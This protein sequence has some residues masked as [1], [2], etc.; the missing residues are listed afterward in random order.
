MGPLLMTY[1]LMSHVT[2]YRSLS[3]FCSMVI[4][5]PFLAY[6]RSY[7]LL[8]LTMQPWIHCNLCMSIT[9]ISLVVTSC[10]KVVC[11]SCKP[12]LGQ[13]FCS[14]CR[15]P[16]TKTIP[17]DNGAPKEVLNLFTDINEQLKTVFKNFNFQESQK[18]SLLESK[19]RKVAQM[20]NALVE[21]ANQNKDLHAKFA[22]MKDCLAQLYRTEESLKDKF[23]RMTYPQVLGY[24]N[25]VDKFGL[26]GRGDDQSKWLAG[27]G[28][29][30]NESFR[31]FS[32][33]NMSNVGSMNI[34]SPKAEIKKHGRPPGAFLEMKTPA[35]WYYK[36]QK[37]NAIGISPK[38]RLDDLCSRKPH[39]RSRGSSLDGSLFF[40]ATPLPKLKG[41]SSRRSNQ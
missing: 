24:G 36:Q 19:E 2:P 12:K 17:L 38:E 34:R 41:S 21:Y 3:S 30:L 8:I 6:F 18:R 22:Q 23:R 1:Q 14:V 20:K 29:V 35:A 31:D 27:P 28:Q 33:K 32:S 9:T 15:G 25:D 13:T 7:L 4:S 37:Q 40:T 26:R 10:G 5:H 39:D 11:T 16:C